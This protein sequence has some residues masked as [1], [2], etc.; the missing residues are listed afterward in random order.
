MPPPSSPQTEGCGT[1]VISIKW[2]LGIINRMPIV[3]QIPKCGCQSGP[4]KLWSVSCLNRGSA[5]QN[6]L[7][8]ARNFWLDEMMRQARSA[9]GSLGVS[10]DYVLA[11]A[12]GCAFG[13]CSW[14]CFWITQ[15]SHAMTFIIFSITPG[16]PPRSHL[17]LKKAISQLDRCIVKLVVSHMRYIQTREA[18]LK[19]Q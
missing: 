17:G 14:L 18:L 5:T 13:E 19:Q 8:P 16:K 6:P 9:V 11:N 1:N 4:V 3:V 15:L 10:L 7:S 2:F 12:V